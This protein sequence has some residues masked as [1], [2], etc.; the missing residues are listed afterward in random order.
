MSQRKESCPRGGPGE[1]GA[2][3][4]NSPSWLRE[5]A[6]GQVLPGLIL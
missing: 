3:L 2:G 1:R 6:G 4:W 5:T